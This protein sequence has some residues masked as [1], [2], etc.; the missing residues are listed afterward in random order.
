MYSLPQA[1]KIANNALVPYLASHGYHQCTH[2]P[3]LFKHSTRP[4]IFSLVVNDFG[5]QYVGCKNAQ[6]LADIIAA[7]YKMTTDWTGNL[8]VGI[9]LKWGYLK[10]TV[11]LSMPGYVAKALQPPN[12]PQNSPSE[13]TE[14]TYGQHAP[15]NPWMPPGQLAFRKS[16]VSSSTTDA[17]WTTPSLLPTVA[18]QLPKPRA[19]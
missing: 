19:L 9:T 18:L 11:D 2:T 17:Q 4:I 13:W 16:L 10:Q 7:K 14:P 12:R 6:H 15:P 3:G 8:N 5:V 1:G